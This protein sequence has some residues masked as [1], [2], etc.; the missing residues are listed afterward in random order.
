MPA[1]KNGYQLE[2]FGL[3]AATLSER[4]EPYIEHFGIRR[5]FG[6]RVAHTRAVA[7]A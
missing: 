2:E 4:F 5:E 6:Q 3:S 1:G 7:A